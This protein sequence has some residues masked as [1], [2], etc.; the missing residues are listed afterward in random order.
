MSNLAPG[1]M[2]L[3]T[4]KPDMRAFAGRGRRVEVRT[5]RGV[6]KCIV[7]LLGEVLRLVGCG[8]RPY[9]NLDGED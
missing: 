2:V 4:A 3:G 7:V 6:E 1:A 9:M 8:Y 5:T